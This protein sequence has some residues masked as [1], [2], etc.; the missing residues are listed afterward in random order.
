MNTNTPTPDEIDG[1]Q[2]FAQAADMIAGIGNQVTYWLPTQGLQRR[3]VVAEREDAVEVIFYFN[4]NN[5]Q[6]SAAPHGA[7]ETCTEWVPKTAITTIENQR[8]KIA[9]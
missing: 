8:V 3:R 9:A 4:H 2:V 1:T 7:S 5:G 6:R